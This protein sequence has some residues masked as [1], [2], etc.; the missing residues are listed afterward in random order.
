LDRAHEIAA[1]ELTTAL[2]I[3]PFDLSAQLGICGA[4]TGHPQMQAAI[5]KWRA[6]A[7]SAGKPTW[8]IG[9]GPKLVEM[10]FRFICIGEPSALLTVSLRS[11]VE[12]LHRSP[13]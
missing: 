3:G 11:Q 12:Q 13:S 8:M 9:P 1:H 4:P 10:G 5:A 6:A 7:A 2:G